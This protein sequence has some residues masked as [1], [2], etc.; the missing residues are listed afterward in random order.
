M[1]LLSRDASSACLFCWLLPRRHQ[2]LRSCKR[3]STVIIALLTCSCWCPGAFLMCMRGTGSAAVCSSISERSWCRGSSMITFMTCY[4]HHDAALIWAG[5]CPIVIQLHRFLLLYLIVSGRL[6][7]LC[8]E[9]SGSL[10]W[11]T[12]SLMISYKKSNDQL[13]EV[14]SWHPVDHH[15][16]WGHWWSES[17]AMDQ[18]DM[19]S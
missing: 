14:W 16:W 7:C 1:K 10:C 4:C 9:D 17:T 15:H 3:L 5:V 2:T 11:A 6:P 8:K 18:A 19:V 13:H 12:W